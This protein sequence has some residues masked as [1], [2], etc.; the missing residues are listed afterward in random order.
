MIAL[1]IL[2]NKLPLRNV[3]FDSSF[4][5]EKKMFMTSSF[6]RNKIRDVMV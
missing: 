2:A 1:K 6:N 5:R 3:I 4:D